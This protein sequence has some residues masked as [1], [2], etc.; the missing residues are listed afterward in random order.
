MSF[1]VA[2]ALS[3]SR[4]RRC[5]GP[6][7]PERDR[8][9]IVFRFAERGEPARKARS[10][11]ASLGVR[12]APTPIVP[13][14]RAEPAAR[15]RRYREMTNSRPIDTSIEESANYPVRESTST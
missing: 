6:T 4:L 5:E 9:A 1:S 3:A 15:W 13:S 14:A 2:S 8:V 7:S 11:A 10:H 12:F